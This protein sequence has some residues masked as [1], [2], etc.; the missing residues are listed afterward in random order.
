M[1]RLWTAAVVVSRNGILRTGLLAAMAVTLCT[2][3][4]RAHQVWVETTP[5][6]KAG[7]A[8]EITVCWGHSGHKEAGP[9]LAGQQDKLTAYVVSPSGRESVK[10]TL[11]D[12]GFTGKFTPTAPGPY[13][14]GADL[15][16][17]IIDRDFHGIPAKTRIVMCGKSLTVVKGGQNGAVAP[18]GFD[19]EIVPV[20]MK[21]E[22]KPGDLITVRVL[23]NGKPIGGRNVIV[24]AAT[25]GT[26][27]I[28]DDPRVQTGEW[29]IDATAD[30]KTGEATF[31]LIVGGQHMFVIKYFDET[32]GTYNGDRNDSSSFSHLRKG[33]TYER[34]MYV[35]TLTIQVK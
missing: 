13:V 32:P 19:L 25:Q 27:A 31:P 33:D 20:E 14:I 9:R 21:A 17:G 24:S 29:S 7:T 10:L 3:T 1:N 6:A 12:N 30:P 35:S 16:T 26:V 34:T 11:A 22:P 28:P 18:I 15:Q 2:M 23:H 4:A 5:S 8:H